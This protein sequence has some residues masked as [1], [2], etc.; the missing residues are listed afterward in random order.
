MWYSRIRP[1]VQ[2]Y[3]KKEFDICSANHDF[4]IISDI[5]TLILLDMLDMKTK[6]DGYQLTEL[7]FSS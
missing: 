7:N 3:R 6:L 2:K 4:N 1:Y 5:E